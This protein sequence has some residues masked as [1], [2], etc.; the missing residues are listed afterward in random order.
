M[1]SVTLD[2]QGL[3]TS[4]ALRTFRPFSLRT[5]VTSDMNIFRREDIHYFRQDIIN[6]SQYTVVSG[7]K[8]LIRYSPY[9]PNLIRSTCTSQMRISS[10]CSLH[11]S[12]KVNFR[13]YCDMAFLCIFYNLPSFILCIKTTIGNAVIFSGIMSDDCLRAF[14]TDSGQL[15]T[16]FD[17]NSP[18]LI[19][20]QMPMK[21]VDIV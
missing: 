11:M 8:H 10:Q 4:L 9:F 16:F 17:F 12:R 20:G 21:T 3:D 6:K 13:Y 7:T 18:S 1:F 2:S 14:G 15:R 5:F 19:I